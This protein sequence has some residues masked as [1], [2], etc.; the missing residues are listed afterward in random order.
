MG[1]SKLVALIVV[2]AAF[3]AAASSSEAKTN[4]FT[5][6]EAP[7]E[8]LSS[9]DALR[10]QTLDEIQGM[11]VTHLR[12]VIIWRK[13]DA[14]GWTAYDRAINEAHA[15]GLKLL[16][17]ISG[18]VPKWASA[19]GKSYTY[20]PSPSKFQDF[21][22]AVGNRYRDQVSM[23]SIWNEPNHPGFLT[24]Q[25]AGRKGHRYAYS[26]KLYRSLFL[27]GD[28]G[29]R[30]SGN[31]SDTLL[32]GETEPRGTTKAVP[33]LQFLRGLFAAPGK[34]PADGYAH[35]AYT[36]GAGPTFIPS[37]RDDVTIGVL[38][39]LTRA[40]DSYARRGRIRSKLPVYL[41][42]FGIQSEPDPYIGV[43]YQRQAEYRSISEWYAWKNPRIVA[44][45]QY[46]M[47]DD[48]PRSGST[49]ARY[50]GFESGLRGSSGKAKLAYE[51]FRLP[52]VA[53]ARGKRVYFWGYI[54][55]KRSRTQ[56]VIQIRKKGAKHWVKL[57]TV[58]TN[59]AA[60][61]RCITSLRSG[62]QYRVQWGGYT[63]PATR[64]Y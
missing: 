12:V 26:P 60:Y 15:R 5:L 33:P 34:L 11:G 6:F 37:N 63:G 10:A 23:W 25:Y 29:L 2:A 14:D 59:S 19:N 58:T 24:P 8:L 44:F 9:D 46:L 50:S 56:V 20:K 53:D 54:R 39:R 61:W 40:L 42:E 18:P 28:R 38:S 16:V 3:L 62:A 45:S 35:H 31:G 36:T 22:T 64:A 1:A 17:T 52:L 47:R 21:V 30:A 7:R 41:T 13:A 57:K 48:N 27:A 51:G 49:Y 4:Q 32:I 43:S 55:P